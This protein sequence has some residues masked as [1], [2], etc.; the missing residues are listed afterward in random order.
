MRGSQGKTKPYNNKE[1]NRQWKPGN[2]S[3]LLV[4]KGG[5]NSVTNASFVPP[6]LSGPEMDFPPFFILISRSIKNELD[7]RFFRPFLFFQFLFPENQFRVFFSPFSS[8]ETLF[9]RKEEKIPQLDPNEAIKS[10][11]IGR[12]SFAKSLRESKKACVSIYIFARKQYGTCEKPPN[13]MAGFRCSRFFC[14][15]QKLSRYEKSPDLGVTFLLGIP[16]VQKDRFCR[17]GG[18]EFA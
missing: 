4:S 5:P 14:G 6:R 9:L 16:S 1:K 10:R 3:A 13:F 7:S 18:K 15:I 17:K 8:L 12:L 2:N 11:V